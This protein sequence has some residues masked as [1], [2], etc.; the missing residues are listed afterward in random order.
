MALTFRGEA[1]ETDRLVALSD[2]VVAI[3][4]TLLVL[5][6]SVPEVPPGTPSATVERLVFD[7]WDEFVGYAL[8]FLVIGLYWTLHRRIFVHI[9]A[10]DRGV[11]WLNLVFLL[12]VA[13]VPFGTSVFSAHPN[14][15]GVSFIAGVL[16]LT[17]LTLAFLWVY[18]SRR[19]LLE[20]GLASRAVRIQAAR[21]LVSPL[22]FAASIGV[23]AL[24][25]AWGIATWT[26][27][28][29][30]NAA[31]NSQLVESVETASRTG[32]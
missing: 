8:G 19:Q 6:F 25:S 27:L 10:H 7:Q 5:D 18:A 17:G 3:A 28:I 24:D 23:A 26:L 15:F 12:F 29:P 2:G 21:F 4:I 22:V 11:V 31:L 13:F 9:E 20:A 30:I 1:E 14:R 16:A 32:K